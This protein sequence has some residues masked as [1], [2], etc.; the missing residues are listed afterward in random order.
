VCSQH[1]EVPIPSAIAIQQTLQQ[2]S[3]NLERTTR[4]TPQLRQYIQTAERDIEQVR[5]QVREVTA[6]L[7][8]ALR[9]DEAAL[10]LRDA[11]ARRGRVIGRISLWLESIEDGDE[12]SSLRS[13]EE[14]ARQ[15]VSDLES[16]LDPAEKEERLDSIMNLMGIEMTKWASELGLEYSG[17]PV[18]FDPKRLTVVVDADPPII[19][20]RMGSGRNYLSYHLITHLALHTHFRVHNRPVPGFLFLDQPTLG[21]YP[22][23]R[24]SEMSGSLSM[25]DDDDRVAV[26]QIFT[27]IFSHAAEIPDFQV[28]ITDHANLDDEN[29]QAAL[30]EEEW[31]VGKA[32]IPQAWLE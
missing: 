6:S 11:N 31:V 18:R 5:D 21:F 24:K 7:A 15:K 28:I 29:F 10:R 12:T 13:R 27:F 25:L 3:A 19:L 8:A 23:E 9:E 32:L 17:N 14:D 4:E 26:H 1:L 22:R 30:A 2:I 20:T 16:E